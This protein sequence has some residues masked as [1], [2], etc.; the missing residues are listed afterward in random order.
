MEI[1]RERQGNS[2]G[3]HVGHVF[4]DGAQGLACDIGAG[5]GEGGAEPGEAAEEVW[6][7]EDLAVG[8]LRE[9]G[10]AVRAGRHRDPGL[11]SELG[12]HIVAVIVEADGDDGDNIKDFPYLSQVDIGEPSVFGQRYFLLPNPVYGSWQRLPMR[13]CM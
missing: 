3:L 1:I 7:D 9:A 2:S 5:F 10:E 6:G 12:A 8:A 4:A 11:P 13:A